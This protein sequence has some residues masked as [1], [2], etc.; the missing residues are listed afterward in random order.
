M[1]ELTMVKLETSADGQE[2]LDVS[3]KVTASGE[4]I[5]LGCID[6]FVGIRDQLTSPESNLYILPIVGVG[7]LGKTTLAE[8]VFNDQVIVNHFDVS[9]WLTISE[10]Y[11]ARKILLGEGFIRPIRGK[12]LE[13]VAYQ[14]LEELVTRNLILIHKWTGNGKLKEGMDVQVLHSLRSTSVAGGLVCTRL[15]PMVLPSKIWEMPQL[16]HIMVK[17]AILPD[18][19]D[20]QDATILENLQTLSFIHN[21]RCTLKILE[22]IP[23]LKKLKLCYSGNLKDWSYY[24]V[25]NLV[26]LCQLESLFLITK[27]L[28]ME[29]I[30]FPNSLKKLTLS[31]CKLPWEVMKVIGST[32]HNLE[33]LKLYNNAFKGPN[34]IRMKGHF[35]N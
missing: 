13:D 33:V 34:G 32:L 28:L 7:G 27:D 10:E 16:R 11:N 15:D 23:Y 21:L 30:A 12:T 2:P 25:Y 1:E 9:I 22:K 24:C 14:C 26:N 19:S 8:L 20:T 17:L 3:S 6:Q 4:N 31:G 29:K 18:P 35:L 5:V